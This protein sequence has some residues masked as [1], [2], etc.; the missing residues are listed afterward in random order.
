MNGRVVETRPQP[1]HFRLPRLQENFHRNALNDL[2]EIPG[3]VVGRQ[4]SKLR[5][6]RGRDLVDLTSKRDSRKRVDLDFRVV[7]RANVTDLRL[8][9]VRLHPNIA[10]H[11][12]DD[13]GSWAD[14]LSCADLSFAYDPIFRR[15]DPCI[16]QV[17]R[18][19]RECRA[20]GVQIG[21]EQEFL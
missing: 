13:L 9:V 6:A 19:E 17:S 8:L 21:P 18:C 12:R 2:R 16:T 1:I 7:A 5:P 10:L 20:F 11:Q 14:E 3:C 4:Q 15:D